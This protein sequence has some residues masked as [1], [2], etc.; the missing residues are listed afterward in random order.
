MFSNLSLED[1]VYNRFQELCFPRIVGIFLK[2]VMQKLENFGNLI[3]S[4]FKFPQV[5]R[6]LFDNVILTEVFKNG[7][8]D[9]HNYMEL[10]SNKL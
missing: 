9:L 3:L 6:I 2:K 10:T 7:S 1:L 4:H 5:L 8:F